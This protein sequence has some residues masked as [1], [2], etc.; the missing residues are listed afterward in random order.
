MELEDIRTFVSLATTR[1]FSQTAKDLFLTQPGV[2]RRLQRLEHVLGASLVDRRR[3]PLVLT[4]A[5]T[6][7]LE[8]S[9]HVLDGLAAMRAAGADATVAQRELRIGVAHALTE[10]ALVSPLAR[11]RDAFPRT[12]FLLSTGWS[13]D[14]PPMVR[15]G[16]LDAA[17]VLLPAADGVPRGVAGR[18]LA[19][20]RLVAIASRRSALPRTLRELDGAEWILN[21]H[22][23]A[24]RA[25]LL[26][27]LRRAQVRARVA[28]ETYTYETQ[29]AL[30][31]GGRGF[32]LV[33]ERLLHASRYRGELR[34]LAL[35][36]LRFPLHIW[37]L[38]R[39]L[40]AELASPLQT[41][42]DHLTRELDRAERPRRR[43]NAPT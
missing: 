38:H 5:G 31:G 13:P 41:L 37:V 24:A 9:L 19:R 2:T 36:E 10:F 32:G 20:E 26:D 16:H 11:A 1:S 35:A 15:T 43:S 14:L 3:R 8:H 28:V 30:V 27:V 7:T 18:V 39:P 17:F 34:R 29:L 33:P 6:V 4:A 42:C 21:P 40:P 22:G 23:C 12:G 25:T